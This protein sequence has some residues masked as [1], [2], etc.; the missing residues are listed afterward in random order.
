M[1]R[2]DIENFML[3]TGGKVY[4]TFF[5]KEKV[6]FQPA[7]AVSLFP[8]LFERDIS[9]GK[10]DWNWGDLPSERGLIFLCLLARMGCSPIVEFGTLRGRT[11]YNLALNSDEVVTTVDI[12]NVAG[13]AIDV[14]ANIEKHPYPSHKTGELFLNGPAN[15]RNKIR[16]V[17]GD[18]T[19]LEFPELYGKAGLVIVDGGHSYEVC[20]SDSVKALRLVKEGGVIVWDDYGSYWPGVKQALDE[21]S[22]SIQLYYLP[23][24]H[25]I[26]H[27]AKKSGTP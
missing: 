2:K 18:S 7:S 13:E 14:G 24:E 4:R 21:L 17:I 9:L 22:S 19:K 5:P 27:I 25:F 16:Q 11:T 3:R 23:Q 26:V 1:S 8:R 12:G 10:L 15:V 20:K 6:P